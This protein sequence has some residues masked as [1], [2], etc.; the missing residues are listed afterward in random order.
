MT[1]Q[2]HSLTFRYRRRDTILDGLSITVPPGLTALLGANGAGKSTLMRVLATELPTPRGA[3]IELDGLAFTRCHLPALRRTLG[4]VP[5]DTAVRATDTVRGALRIAASLRDVPRR[6]IGGAV[7]ETIERV[8]LQ[9]YA[10]RRIGG[11]SGGYQ[12]K[13]MIALG[14]VHQP[15]TV[16]LDEPTSGLDP[17]NR[18]DIMELVQGISSPTTSVLMSTHLAAD[19]ESADEIAF[20]SN[21][22]VTAHAPR[23]EFLATYGSI[24]AAFTTVH[25]EGQH[26]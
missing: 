7:D 11:L 19:T 8:G 24:D 1:L 18:H 5:Q 17:A 2:C 26:G 9:K 12:R 13:A 6:R 4:W 20:L 10:D 21:G 16:L 25:R 22:Q 3:A 15:T 14:L 23:A